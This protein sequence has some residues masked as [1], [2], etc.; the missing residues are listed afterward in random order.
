M[1]RWLIK[2][3]PPFDY[4]LLHPKV[5]I[6]QVHVL[7]IFYREE[8]AHLFVLESIFELELTARQD[9]QS[10][11]NNRCQACN[12]QVALF[13][14]QTCRPDPNLRLFINHNRY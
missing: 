2:I 5:A 8:Y 3:D 13:N 12:L 9:I 6:F 14:L 1:N 11:R 7:Q 4:K 10:L